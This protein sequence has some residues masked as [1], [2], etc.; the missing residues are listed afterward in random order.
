MLGG[1]R[2]LS[3]SEISGAVAAA[4]IPKGCS[5]KPFLVVKTFPITTEHHQPTTAS[6]SISS[7]T[8]DSSTGAPFQLSCQCELQCELR[9][10]QQ[11]RRES[12]TI[13]VVATRTETSY[14][15]PLPSLSPPPPL[16][17]LPPLPHHHRRNRCL[18]GE[19]CVR[20]EFNSPAECKFHAKAAVSVETA[21][22]AITIT[23]GGSLQHR[24]NQPL[25]PP[26][27]LKS[28]QSR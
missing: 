22:N 26:P 20:R 10:A 28:L 11:S 18:C 21:T 19:C 4:T 8:T 13:T 6:P 27:P 7:T 25:P 12:T 1:C 17:P 9:R 14:Q 23:S 5:L 2:V 24:L 16:S 3:R 15:P